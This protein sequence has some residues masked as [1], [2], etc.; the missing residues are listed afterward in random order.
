LRNPTRWDGEAEV[1]ILNL[2]LNVRRVNIQDSEHL[3]VD[4]VDVGAGAWDNEVLVE[5]GEGKVSG[6]GGQEWEGAG[7]LP[8]EAAVVSVLLTLLTDDR[9]NASDQTSVA[10]SAHE[11]CDILQRAQDNIGESGGKSESVLQVVDGEVVL[12]RKDR[13][14][15]VELGEGV[16][17]I[18]GMQLFL[19]K[20]GSERS[21]ERVHIQAAVL[22]GRVAGLDQLEELEEEGDLPELIEGDQSQR[23][24]GISL[25]R[26]WGS[27]V[28]R[29]DG[30]MCLGLDGSQLSCC[31]RGEV[32]AQRIIAEGEGWRSGNERK[33]R[34][35][36]YRERDLGE[37]FD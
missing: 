16:V 28:A 2:R 25:R 13:S 30:A 22:K 14:I 26:C 9:G 27:R 29:G 12:A 1:D 32:V 35:A 11:C 8:L 4:G 33:A 6:A 23:G 24:E 37:H 5:G 18:D 7:D 20:N 10:I 19:C 36:D 21:R 17:S 15:R 3:E 31:R 34:E